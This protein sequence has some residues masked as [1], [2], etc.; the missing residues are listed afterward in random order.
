MTDSTLQ[1]APQPAAATA[2]PDRARK[3]AM[4]VHYMMRQGLDL[5]L[6]SLPAAAQER[7]TRELAAL[8]LIDKST[9]D[10]A[11]REFEAALQGVAVS[12]PGGI[13]G[14]LRALDG[15]VSP[16]ILAR[17]REEASETGGA[18]PWAQVLALPIDDLVPIF[19]AES[20]EIASVLLSKL[21][22]ARAAEVLSRLPGP[23]ARRVAY[24]RSRTADILPEVVGRVGRAL[25][26]QYCGAT[27]P[28]FHN[29]APQRVGA[30]LN[31]AGAA[32]RDSLLS[33]LTE[34]DAA[35]AE[36]VRK[37]IFTFEDIPARLTPTDLPKVTRGIDQADLVTALAFGKETG[38]R[39]AETVDFI[40]ANISKRLSEALAE[41]M[42]ERG[43]VKSA[44]GEAAQTALIT[45]IRAAADSGEITL[46]TPE[47]E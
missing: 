7:L 21:P 9:L 47:E 8:R 45:A 39:S 20:T 5:P 2:A 4:I 26:H 38:G 37:A 44:D 11:I 41:E 34:D 32:T 28:A 24:G 13:E 43:K 10:A 46:L 17:L 22:T 40:L 19:E 6:T 35:F 18:D 31:I 16:D 3:A 27:A 14:A 25:A 30:I 15:R 23:L 1:T 12:A 29:P 36:G 42:G 33:A